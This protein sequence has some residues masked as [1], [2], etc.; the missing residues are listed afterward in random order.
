MTIELTREQEAQLKELV[1]AG[2]FDSVEQF[3][4]YSLA[5]V[6]EENA[7]HTDWLRAETRKGLASL[8]AGRYSEMTTEEIAA[9]GA[10]QLD[11]RR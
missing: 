11:L 5:A 3:I 4:S 9:T 7:E 6:A 8:D 2:K 10:R 1:E